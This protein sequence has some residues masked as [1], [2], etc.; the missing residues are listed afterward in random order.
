MD[1]N[2]RSEQL[3]TEILNSLAELITQLMAHGERLAQRF[4]FPSFFIKALHT[5]DCPMAMKELGRRLHCDPSFVTVIADGLE[6]RG[7]A[8]RE[9]HPGDRRIRN[10]VLTGAGVEMRQRMERELAA[11]MP[12]SSVLDIHE[13]EQLLTLLRKMASA[14]SAV[15]PD[16]DAPY[17]P[18]PAG[19]VDVA[20]GTASAGL[21]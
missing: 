14:G 21:A 1:G 5:L 20:V 2:G 17:G 7:L 3:D 10:I 15:A 18:T 8:R 6:K 11:V 12:W 19:E 13:R 9:A 4:S 16:D